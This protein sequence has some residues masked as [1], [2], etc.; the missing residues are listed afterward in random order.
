MHMLSSKDLTSAELEPLQ[1]SRIPTTVTTTNWEVHTSEE[2][3]ENFH[4]LELFVTV[5]ILDDTPA[6]LSLGVLCEEHGGA[7]E[8]ASGQKQHLTKNGK[9]ILC[10]KEK[11]VLIVLPGLSSSSSAS[12]SCTSEPLD[13]LGMS[14]ARLRSDDTHAQTS[15]NRGDPTKTKI[16]NQKKGNN[17]ATSC[18]LRDLPE[19]LEEFTCNLEHTEV[20]STRNHFSRFRFETTYESGNQETY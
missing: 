13:S 18:R 14:P 11:F 5:Q 10:N 19:R 16:K 6:V 20:P 3:E 4:D 12:S 7:N 17:Q 2:V 8:W 9:T 1:K 15:G